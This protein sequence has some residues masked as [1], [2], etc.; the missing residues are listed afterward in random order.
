MISSEER[1]ARVR[2]FGGGA[3]NRKDPRFAS[4]FSPVPDEPE[5][6]DE[7]E[8]AGQGFVDEVHSQAGGPIDYVV[9]HAGERAFSRS[10]Q[11]LGEGGI[12][13]FFGATS[14]YRFSFMGKPGV[15]KADVMLARAG[16]RAG[17]SLLVIYGPGAEDGI[18][19]PVAI[20]AIEVGCARGARVAV[21]ADTG[22]QREFVT[23]LG[24]G[25]NLS[26]VVSLQDIQRRLGS[27]FDPPGPFMRLPN[28]FT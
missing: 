12:L 10:F 13:T 6:W 20:E 19:D 2:Q 9:S 3:V 1:A 22:A 4:I 26:G 28:A 5:A 24:F 23:S 7:W 8:Q 14:G 16:L 17:K 15:E 21:L 27:D 18:V 25:A 11:L